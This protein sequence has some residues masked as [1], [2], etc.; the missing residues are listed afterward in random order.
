VVQAISAIMWL[1]THIDGVNAIENA[2][3]KIEYVGGDRLEF[4]W[5][6]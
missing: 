1:E 6:I 4:Y 3:G 5:D 2:Y